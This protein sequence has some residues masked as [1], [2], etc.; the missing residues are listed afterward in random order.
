ML[1]LSEYKFN[2]AMENGSSRGYI[3]E[4]IIEAWAAGCIPIY[5]GDPIIA[6][7]F[8]EEAFINYH[9]F[10]SV[11]EI[12]DYILELEQN[13]KRLEKM[14]KTPILEKN[15]IDYNETLESFLLRILSQ[16]QEK[17]YRRKTFFSYMITEKNNMMNTFSVNQCLNY[18]NSDENRI[19]K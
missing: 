4:K 8:N 18:Y 5:W 13:P 19:S 3:T 10:S 7:S 15:M 2:L 17:A 16:K 12:I 1:F 6:K 14:L 9:N 11:Q